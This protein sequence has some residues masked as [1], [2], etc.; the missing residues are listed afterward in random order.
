MESIAIEYPDDIE[1]KAF[2]ALQ[3]YENRRAGLPIQSYLAADG[4]ME[5]IFRAEPMHPTHH[6]RIH[7][8]DLK[9]PERALKSSALCGQS[10]PRIAH[11]WHMP[12]HIFSRLKRYEDAV[13]QQEASARVDHAHMIRD[14]VLPDEI[15]NFAHNNE[16]MIRNLIYI[17]AVQKAIDLAKNMSELPRHPKYNVLTKRGSNRYGRERLFQVLN[18]FGVWD[19]TIALCNSVYLEPTDD[20][21]EQRKRLRALG[22]ALVMADRKEE[23]AKHLSDIQ[24]QIDAEKAKEKKAVEEAKTKAQKEFEEKWDKD[25]KN[26]K[27][28]M[29]DK[30]KALKAALD[31]SRK[32]V[33]RKHKSKYSALEKIVDA[34][35]GFQALK[36][37]EF[38]TAY[39]KIKKAGGEDETLIA[40]IQFLMG[41]QDKALAAIKKSIGKRKNEVIPHCR[42]AYLLD[43]AGKKDEAKK[44]FEELRK[45]SSSID[46]KSELFTRLEG[47]ARECGFDGDWRKEKVFAKDIGNRPDLDDL[48]PIHWTPSP[49]PTFELKKPD[50]TVFNLADYKGRPV[51]IIFYLGASCLHCAEQLQA[52]APEK[53]KFADAGIELVA[54]STD[55]PAKLNTS[56]ADYGDKMPIPLMSNDKLD[57]FKKFRAYD[58]FEKQP[59]HGTYLIDE[60]GLVRWQDIS[61]EPFMDHKFLYKEALRLLAQ[62]KVSPVKTES[63]PEPPTAE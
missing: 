50:G 24:Q 57:V 23:A 21:R 12:G 43:K 4:L 6:F 45:I 32:D 47:L 49:A 20:E 51:V 10:A 35:G 63:K 9:K 58:D 2:L 62:K 55:D 61:Y 26:K 19:Q 25:P 33:E 16:W 17:G 38:K 54:I 22:I 41:E 46:M 40:E 39:E 31:K 44:A 36:D 29:E 60:N 48:G 8:W 13:W 59:L 1:A 56:L 53:K 28:S 15:H 42:Y 14:R 37:G 52:F 5:E 7:L 27:K 18:K 3:I 34:I 11:M 30:A